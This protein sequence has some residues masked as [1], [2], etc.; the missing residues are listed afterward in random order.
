MRL[1]QTLKKSYSFEGKGLHTGRHARMTICPAP[2][3]YGIR[4]RRTDIGESAYV[5]ALAENVSSTARSTTIS[6]GEVSVSTI[7]H[8][9]SCGTSFTGGVQVGKNGSA[10]DKSITFTVPAG[11][12]KIEIYANSAS[13]GVDGDYSV[14][15]NGAAS[16]VPCLNASIT[17]YTA[18]VAAG[19]NIA[20]YGNSSVSTNIWGIYIY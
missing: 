17:C 6:C 7:E 13:S 2:E 11:C 15:V 3:D 16:V 8:V 19:D 4:F 9:L 12:T 1:Q 20:I 5:E 14:S 10:A 18:T